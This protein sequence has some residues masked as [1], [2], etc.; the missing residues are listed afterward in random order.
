M[1]TELPKDWKLVRLGDFVKTEKGKKPKCVSTIKTKECSI[2]YVNI[3]AFE[4]IL[5]MNIQMELVVLYV[6]MMIF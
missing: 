4:K 3:K 2:P 5:L 1:N 6:K